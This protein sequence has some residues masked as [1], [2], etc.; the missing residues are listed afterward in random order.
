MVPI[1][2]FLKPRRKY[3]SE[4]PHRKALQQQYMSFLL[5]HQNKRKA[6]KKRNQVINS[7]AKD[8]SFKVGDPVYYRNHARKSKLDPKRQSYYGILE[9]TLPVTFVIKN[10]LDGLKVKVHTQHLRYADINEFVDRNIRWIR[11]YNQT[12]LHVLTC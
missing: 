8:V 9:Q 6:M 1:D 3:H 5:V 11:R 12:R 4:E 2:Y 7:K 10:Q